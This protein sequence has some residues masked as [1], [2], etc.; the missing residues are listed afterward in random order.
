MNPVSFP[1]IQQ[2]YKLIKINKD[3]YFST[4]TSFSKFSPIFMYLERVTHTKKATFGVK[5]STS[6]F[7]IHLLFSTD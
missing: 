5:K 2:R 4:G 1:F 3:G 7:S 6:N